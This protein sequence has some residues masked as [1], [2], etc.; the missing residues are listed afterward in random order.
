ME[1]NDA[2]IAVFSRNAFYK[3][4]H[5]LALG[6]LGLVLVV[7]GILIFVLVYLTKNPSQPLYFA[8]DTVGR[9]IQITPV[10]RPNMTQ[11]ELNAWVV[12]AVQAAYSYDYLNY[13]AELQGAQ[14]YFSNYGWSKYMQALQASNNLNGIIQRQWIAL[15]KVIDTPKV[16]TEG[17]LGGAY[18][19]KFQIS[20]LVTYLR[21]PAYDMATM[22][23]DPL[24]ISV[25]V[26]RQPILQSYKGLGIVQMV[27]SLATDTDSNQMQQPISN[28][29]TG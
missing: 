2:L 23:A 20:L 25:I 7:I 21:P 13:R 19:W 26:Q 3:R 24:Q 4:L 10:D 22:R 8:T 18:A 28:T 14:K 5:F 15:A 12:E 17:M 27:G 16:V 9:L 6:M 11:D 29:P 1:T